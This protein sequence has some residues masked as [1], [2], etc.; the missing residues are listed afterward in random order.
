[1]GPRSHA[2]FCPGGES[3]GCRWPL[4]GRSIFWGGSAF[5]AARSPSPGSAR[6]RRGFSWP[7]WPT[8][9]API[10]CATLFLTSS[11]PTSTP[12]PPQ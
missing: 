9:P 5:A 1:M 2:L 7:I 10:T 11:G 4:T 8:I 3:E 12:I 6:R